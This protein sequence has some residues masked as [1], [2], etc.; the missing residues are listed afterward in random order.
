M[1]KRIVEIR[2][3][4]EVAHTASAW[5]DRRQVYK[6]VTAD[7][8]HLLSADKCIIFLW[9]E[10]S[11]NLQAQ[12][13]AYGLAGRKLAE[14]A[15]DMG[16]PADPDSLWIALEE[17]DYILLNEGD[18][19]PTD[20]V[21]T[22]AQVDRLAAMLAIL[23]VSG[24]IHGT[25]LVAGRDRPFSDQDGEL[26]ALFAVPIA[27]SIENA[28]LNQ[29]LLDRTE[30]LAA[31][32]DDLDRMAKINQAVRM[33][34]SVI[35]GYLELLLEGAMG[36]VP[37]GQI[38]AMR[39]VLDK[40]EAITS[41]INRVSPQRLPH[42]ATRYDRVR[43]ADLVYGILRERAGDIKQAD[44]QLVTQLPAP[45]DKESTTLGDPNML[46]QVFDALLDNA[47]KINTAGGTIR[48][49]LNMSHGIIYVEIAD[50]GVGIP[51]HQL[52]NIWK[53]EEQPARPGTINLA[54]VKRIVEGH[55]GQV[56]AE[57]K[58]GQGSTFYVALRKLDHRKIKAG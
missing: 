17:E 24:R 8:A 47:I 21:E 42:D 7:I 44:L 25:V 53:N 3:V 40:T 51:T 38:T 35:R 11:G 31:T 58:P 4:R 43:I 26:L 9:D 46:F 57:S 32:W 48:I 5:I 56:W 33:P 23:R 29:R 28:R 13:P 50:S 34:L 19:A 30:Q 41:L 45:N 22:S 14:L 2:A 37:E 6:H 49:S 18:E 1:F 16:H 10:Q 12:E 52:V 15:L 54:E 39:M 36:P 27:L 20:M 55:G